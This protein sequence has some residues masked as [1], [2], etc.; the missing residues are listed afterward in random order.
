MALEFVME[1]MPESVYNSE[2]Y[3]ADKTLD[4]LHKCYIEGDKLNYSKCEKEV[5]DYT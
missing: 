5:S 3:D 1:F 2:P 4:L